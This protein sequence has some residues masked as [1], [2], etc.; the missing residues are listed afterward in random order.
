MS[1]SNNAALNEILKQ[2]KDRTTRHQA[3]IDELAAA[4]ANR[5]FWEKLGFTYTE[6]ESDQIR[7]LRQLIAEMDELELKKD[8]LLVAAG[9]L[10]KPLSG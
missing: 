6:D 4:A 5:Q 8:K 10:A 3:L 1:E 9:I 2:L 7:A